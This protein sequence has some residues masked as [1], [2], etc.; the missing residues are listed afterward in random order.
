MS[1]AGRKA[2][3]SKDKTA[4]KD[5]RKKHANEGF[6]ALLAS[7]ESGDPQA[8]HRVAHCYKFG[9][10]VEQDLSEMERWYE[11]AGD[12][13]DSTAMWDL[14][15]FHLIGKYLPQ[16]TAKALEWFGRAVDAGNG[17]AAYELA[18]AYRNGQFVEKDLEQARVWLGRASTLGNKKAA[19]ELNEVEGEIARQ[20]SLAERR[21]EA[22]GPRGADIVLKGITQRFGDKLVL[23]DIS[24]SIK[25]GELVAIVGGSGGGKSTLVNIIRGELKPTSGSVEF[26]GTCGFVPQA[27][28]V[29]G[30]LTV[31]QQL[32]FYADV[33]K[34]VPRPEREER[35]SGVIEELDL[36][37]SK[38]SLIRTCSGGEVR[39]VSVACELLAR[40]DSLMLDEP[41]S[42]LDP[43]DSGDLIDV[44]HDLVVNNDM[45][46]VVINHDYENISL[47]DKIVFLAKGKVCF[48]GTP[49]RLFDYFETTSAR[50]I[51][52]L[53]RANPEPF[54][55]RFEEW[56]QTNPD[57]E[58][59]IR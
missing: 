2:A 10:G 31:T 16:D 22:D 42:G 6:A 36:F 3:A 54:I 28:L 44:L 59:G 17:D 43:G 38:D 40:P 49:E 33:V 32:R 34:R 56:R 4:S 57:S 25:G 19:G 18:L 30:S 37:R 55:R 8:M 14:G 9:D 48:Y 52:D 13:G 26:K 23:D 12:A 39:R 1:K 35:I 7:A 29:H 27:N 53:M 45:T 58:G 51:Y 50:D 21:S 11:R 24:L 20:R 46:T 15:Y 41:T 47:F 5:K